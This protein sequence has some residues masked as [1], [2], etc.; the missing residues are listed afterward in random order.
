M[1]HYYK[2][3]AEP[4]MKI[5][6]VKEGE[7]YVD[8]E[9]EEVEGYRIGVK[10]DGAWIGELLNHEEYIVKTKQKQE[11]LEEYQGEIDHRWERWQVR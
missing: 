10:I 6:Q 3:L 5:E 11:H 8:V 4:I 1:Y 9:T 2:V 7:N